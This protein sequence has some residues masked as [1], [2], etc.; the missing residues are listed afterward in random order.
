[1]PRQKAENRCVPNLIRLDR[2]R[3]SER[4]GSGRAGGSVQVDQAAS[5]TTTTFTSTTTSV[6]GDT[7]T[8]CS[9]TVFSGPFGMRT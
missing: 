1:M 2:Q 9:P 7:E 4:G 5:P 8:R 6:C 3:L